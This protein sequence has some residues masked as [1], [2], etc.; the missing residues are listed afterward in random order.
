M[1][2]TIVTLIGVIGAAFFISVALTLLMRTLALKFG[3]TDG[4]DGQ[5]KLQE[6]PIPLGGGLAVFFA[7]VVTLTAVRF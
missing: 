2:E 5:R 6:K 1:R 7:V 4:P 3:F